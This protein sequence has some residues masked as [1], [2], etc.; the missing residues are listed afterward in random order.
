[1]ELKM[2][3]KKIDFKWIVTIFLLGVCIHLQYSTMKKMPSNYDTNS[4]I[5]AMSINQEKIDKLSYSIDSLDSV[6]ASI[7]N[8]IHKNY[9]DYETNITNAY[10]SSDSVKFKYLSKDIDSMDRLWEKGYYVSH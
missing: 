10:Y 2:E 8:D 3:Q 1:M 9:N 7:F 4:I 6:K 5:E